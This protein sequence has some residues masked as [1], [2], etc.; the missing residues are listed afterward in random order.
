MEPQ[1]TQYCQS[2]PEEK[3][4]SW[5]HN[6]SRLQ[7]ILQSYSNQNSVVL[8]HRQTYRLMEQNR[9]PKYKPTHRRSTN[10]QKRRQ[11]YTREKRW[12]LQQM[13]LAKLESCMQTNEVR[14]FS[15]HTQ[16]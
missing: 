4:Q 15:H 7:T 6:P 1:K 10:F 2:T 5:R 11:E 8:A 12:S 9:V 14:I 13:V 16:K 3:E